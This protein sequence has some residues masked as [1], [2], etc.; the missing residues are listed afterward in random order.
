MALSLIPRTP[1]PPPPEDQ[2]LPEESP[3]VPG[4]ELPDEIYPESEPWPDE[5]PDAFPGEIPD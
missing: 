4:P 5:G 2:P 3:S 1:I